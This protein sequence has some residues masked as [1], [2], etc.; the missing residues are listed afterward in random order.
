MTHDPVHKFIKR[1]KWRGVLLEPQQDVFH[2][3]LKPLYAQD[4]GI[5][6]VNAALGKH[7]GVMPLYK[8]GFS[9]ARW[10]TGLASF[11]KEVVEK[12]FST[13]H[14]QRQAKKEGVEIP[15]DPERQIISEEIPVLSVATMMK[16]YKLNKIDLLQ[17]DTEGFDY[18]I[19]KMFD[20][21]Q[22]PPRVI[23]YENMHLSET[24]RLA[25]R[26]YLKSH[27]YFIRIMNANTLAMQQPYG[28]LKRFFK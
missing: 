5:E 27:G 21:K 7:D 13:G 16:K 14:V 1:D 9:K 6:V 20:L 24:D 25:C 10:A 17:V 26:E 18:E 15:P 11:R 22:L 23:V 2:T 4:E 19:V 8:I 3:W 28:A 12:A